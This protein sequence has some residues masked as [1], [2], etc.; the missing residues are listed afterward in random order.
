MRSKHPPALKR[1]STA[2]ASRDINLPVIE[3]GELPCKITGW[4]WWTFTS[5]M[6]RG[7]VDS[8]RRPD[9]RHACQKCGEVKQSNGRCDGSWR[10]RKQLKH[11]K[12]LTAERSESG[13]Q[14]KPR[15]STLGDASEHG[16][17]PVFGCFFKTLQAFEQVT[18]LRL[19]GVADVGSGMIG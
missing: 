5:E 18:H 2:R 14:A 10:R 11:P 4:N 6:R 17:S 12:A 19:T 7:Q 3:R 15:K 8:V 13:G 9:Q 16:P 1:R